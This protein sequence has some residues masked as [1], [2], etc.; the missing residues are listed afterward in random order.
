MQVTEAESGD[1]GVSI[2]RTGLLLELVP[3]P[4]VD[5]FAEVVEGVGEK[6]KKEEA[7]GGGGGGRRG[8]RSGG[9]GGS[10]PVRADSSTQF[11]CCHACST[12]F[13][14]TTYQCHK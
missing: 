1:D 6:R 9:G 2:L 10:G 7:A 14:C 5:E 12:Q 13:S 11:T 4:A 3:G 8:E